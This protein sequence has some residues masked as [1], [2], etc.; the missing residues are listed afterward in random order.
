[1][2]LTEYKQKRRFSKTSEPA[3]KAGKRTGWRY[4]IQ[5][6]DASRLHYDFRLELDHVLKSWAVPKGPCLDPSVK[7]LAVEV[8]DHPVGYGTFEGIIPEGEYGGGTVL[9]WDT[10]RWEPVGD[11]HTGL[12]TGRLKFNLYGQKLHGAWALIR[13]RASSDTDSRQWLLIKERDDSARRVSDGDILEELPLSVATGRELES[14]AKAE[15]SVRSSGKAVDS[16]AKR[17]SKRKSP[18]AKS[19]KSAKAVAKKSRTTIKTESAIAGAIQRQ[20]PD[21]I[22]VQLA[23]LT[24]K[25]PDGDEWLHEI[26]FDGY[27]MV[28]R[29][30]GDAVKLI[31]RNHQEWTGRLNQMIP[32]IRKLAAHQAILDGEVVAVQPDGTTDFQ[33]LQNAFRDD[34]VDGLKY[35]VFDLLYLDGRSLV[36][37]PL[38]ERKQLLRTLLNDSGPNETVLLSDHVIGAGED[39]Q[40]HACRLHLEGMISKRRDQPYR[41]GRG[42]GWLK[43][44]CVHKD[45]F[46]IGGYTEPQ[47]AR[48]G[49]GAV[50][51]GFHDDKGDLRYA[52]KVGTGFD[53]YALKELS[54]RFQKLEQQK[55]PFVDI[56]KRTGDIRAAHWM[57][58]SL[59]GQFNYGNRTRDGR[60]RHASFQG[61]REDKPANQVVLDSP[62]PVDEAVEKFEANRHDGSRKDS[63]GDAGI[64]KTRRKRGTEASSFRGANDRN[65]RTEKPGAQ[66]PSKAV[67][68]SKSAAEETF[69][70]VRLTHPEKIL[71]PDV[72]ITKQ[73]LAQY[74]KDV[75][76]W[77]LPHLRHR[78]L[79]VVRCPDGLGGECFY[80]KHPGVGTP[81]NLR[82]IP[83]KE[84]QKNEN[85]LIIDDV[86]GLISLAQISVLELHVWGSREDNLEKP[87]RLIFDLDPAPDVPWDQIV[88]GAR[89]VRAFLQ[90]LGLESFVKTTGGKGLHLV[91]PIDRRHDW[92]D[93]KSFCKRVAE[94]IVTAAPDQYTSNMSKA[95]RTGKIFVDY[96]R[97]GR[98]ATAVAPYS[99]RS[100][101]NAGVSTP[102]AWEELSP[103]M[104]SDHFTV[105]NI[106]RRL[107]SV[108]RDPWSEMESIHQNLSGPIRKLKALE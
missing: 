108:R 99:M 17:H 57:K 83:I 11:P 86:A 96:L 56:K 63:N 85:Y 6:H 23:T 72:G 87:D 46:V 75:S 79:V 29:I 1:M 67:A 52:G 65:D 19:A 31:S 9:L 64:K 32:S 5:K 51:I 95:T 77:M 89:R 105:R 53:E 16:S 50:L 81:A 73:E 39:F 60:L 13:T 42:Y 58:P 38:E 41:A 44:K 88:N 34:R 66:S 47:G 54:D 49:F 12:R 107:R 70:S 93:A 45:E 82:Q 76:E 68:K 37:V 40:Q 27:R 22:D 20:M 35:Y 102:L 48:K 80:Q 15:G 33:S 106:P 21:Q 101:A 103:K 28:C 10:G 55:S 14:I 91:V 4:V 78:P 100:R 2:A 59:V 25:P 26:K 98:G 8:E 71:Y 97:N 61:L 43:T 62:V 90:E 69:D 3:P 30:D 18:I 24:E 74:L 84:K 94:M 7:R 36:E 104:H 92:N